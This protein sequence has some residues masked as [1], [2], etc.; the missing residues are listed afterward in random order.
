MPRLFSLFAVLVLLTATTWSV[1]DARA[2]AAFREATA[3]G[4]ARAI[5]RMPGNTTYL[6][7]GALQTEYDGRDAVPMLAR[8]ARLN[9]AISAPRIRLGLATEQRGDLTTAEHWLLEAFAV[10]H[11]FEP[12]WTLAN[13][14]LR[15][16][17]PDQFWT[18]MHSALEISYGDRRPAFDLCWRFS[19]DAAE[20]LARAIPDRDA[21]AADYLVYLIEHQHAAALAAAAKKVHDQNLLLATTDV[22]LDSKRYSDA[23][24]VWLQ[25]GRKIPDGVTAPNFEDPQSGR[26]F[27]WRR[28]N[29]AGVTHLRLE[30]RGGLRIRLSGSQPESVELLRQFVGGLLPGVRYK[31]KWTQS[32]SVPGIAWRIDGAP[33]TEFVASHEVAQLSLWYQRPLGEVRANATVDVREVTLLPLH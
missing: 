21:V 8:I 24:E 32:A 18:W 4:V 19:S 1:L 3:E 14:Y 2:D 10:D 22:L 28:L 5:S 20:I 13:F 23:V 33:T 26:G 30:D 7:F 16:D 15:H 6:A 31:L 27:D 9:P 29:A 12:R 25:L 17:R 11:Q